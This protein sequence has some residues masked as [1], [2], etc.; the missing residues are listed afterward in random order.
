MRSV[1]TSGDGDWDA[2]R[3]RWRSAANRLWAAALTDA[4]GYR[5]LAEGVGDR[6][7][8]LRRTTATPAE[9]LAMEERPDAVLVDAAAC[10]VRADEIEAERARARR[11]ALVAAGREEGRT[12][13]VL[14]EGFTRSVSMHLPTGLALVAIDEP[15]RDS[16]PHGVAEVAL[17]ADT[18]EVLAGGDDDTAWFATRAERDAALA[19]RRAEIGSLD[20]GGRMVSDER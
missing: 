20:G 2:A 12:W 7:A 6:L 17:A 3:A 10:A 1:E 13:V 5:R 15:Y 16:E 8:E 4:E 11:A 9:L 18:G 14:E 19:Q